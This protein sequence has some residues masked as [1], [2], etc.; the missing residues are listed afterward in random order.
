M[1]RS[2]RQI[3]AGRDHRRAL[4]SLL[5]LG[6]V[7]FF[8]G[9]VG[10]WCVGSFLLAP[11]VES[12]GRPTPSLNAREVAFGSSSGSVLRGWR[13]EG[14]DGEGVVILAH[15]VRSDRR[16]MIGRA[17]F[18]RASGYSVL[19][20]DQ[21]AHGESQGRHITFGYL[22]SRDARAAVAY[23]RTRWPDER[24]G[25]LGVSQGGA[26]ALI[27]AEPLEVDALVV[28]AVFPT[29]YEAMAN[30][31]A[32]RLGALARLAAP[33]LWAQCRLRLGVDLD[34]IAPIH[35]IADIRAPLLLI[36]GG[37][38]RHTTLA[39]SERLFRAAPAPKELWVLPQA[40]HQ[41]FHRLEPRNYERRVLGFFARHLRRNAG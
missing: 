29:L 12:V 32:I 28:E 33:L 35:G 40:V 22:E 19:L 24:I 25:Y 9:A 18:L 11:A 5:I 34:E 26:A 15:S 6:T 17:E 14:R 31:L 21:Q 39:E 36:A 38:D 27:G 10:S 23:A 2:K 20:F 7:I 16:E 8:G 37:K 41:N 30:R 13:A 1:C 3:L 4:Q